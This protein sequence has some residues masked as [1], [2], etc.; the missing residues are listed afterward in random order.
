M[1]C[2]VGGKGDNGKPAANYTLAQWEALKGLLADLRGRFPGAEIKG[3]RDYPGVK[4]DCPCFDVRT[5]LA[6]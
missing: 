1:P 6:K 5:W 2:L 4:K 3:H